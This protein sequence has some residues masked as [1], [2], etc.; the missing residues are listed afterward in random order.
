MG[1]G[2]GTPELE[3]LPKSKNIFG[4]GWEIIGKG[5]GTLPEKVGKKS[6]KPLWEGLRTVRGCS[7]MVLEHSRDNLGRGPKKSDFGP[8][9]GPATLSIVCILNTLSCVNIEHSQLCE[10]DPF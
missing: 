9:I 5:P 10:Y 1:V 8:K 4:N 6:G 2:V 7:P 3:H